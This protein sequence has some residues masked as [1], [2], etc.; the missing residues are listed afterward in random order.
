MAAGKPRR[1]G[2]VIKIKPGALDEYI[3]IHNP[4]PIVYCQMYLGLQYHRLLS[5]T[6]AMNGH[7][8][9]SNMLAKTSMLT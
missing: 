9:L 5:S 4:D 1:F 7:S 3:G 6:T 8:L 2:Q